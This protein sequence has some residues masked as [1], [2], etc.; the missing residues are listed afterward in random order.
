MLGTRTAPRRY[1]AHPDDPVTAA[2]AAIWQLFDNGLIDEDSATLSLLAI[3]LGVRRAAAIKSWQ[4][5]MRAW[6]ADR[7]LTP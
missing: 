7:T 1:M 3:G 6:L 2:Y 5:E 4:T